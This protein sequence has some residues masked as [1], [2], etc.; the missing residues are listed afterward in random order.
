MRTDYEGAATAWTC[1]RK[2]VYPDEATAKKV[3]HRMREDRGANVVHY[4]CTRCGRY[5]IGRAPA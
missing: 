1:A 4:G 5:H 2:K 3:A